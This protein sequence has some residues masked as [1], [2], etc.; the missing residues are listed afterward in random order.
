M[1]PKTSASASGARSTNAASAARDTGVSAARLTRQEVE[2]AFAF[3]DVGGRGYL[4]PK[5]LKD[6]LSV[7]YPNMTNKE[8]RFLI[9]EPRFTVD[10]LWQLL[11][12]H[13]LQGFDPIREAFR[14]YD[15]RDTGYIDRDTLHAVMSS[16]GY[17]QLSPEDL[18]VLLRTADADRDGRISLED[19]RLMVTRHRADGGP[20]LPTP[21]SKSGASSGPAGGAHTASVPA[22]AAS[23]PVP[24]SAAAGGVP[25]ASTARPGASASPLKPV[26]ESDGGLSPA[27][28]G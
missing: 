11:E 25:K 4:R 15:P 17:G 7:F 14:V 2:Q 26:D 18:D 8:Y 28:D 1:P 13:T 3:F 22:A 27:S 16:M 21:P 19:F 23:S 12:H 24:P 5:D 6:R 9:S 10:S 20:L